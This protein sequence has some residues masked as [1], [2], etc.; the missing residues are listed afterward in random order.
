[1]ALITPK[2]HA[3]LVGLGLMYLWCT[4]LIV[5]VGW[6]QS[7]SLFAKVFGIV[8]AA[9]ASLSGTA[10]FFFIND[11]ECRVRDLNE[12]KEFFES[13]AKRWTDQAQLAISMLE[14]ERRRNAQS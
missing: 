5:C 11:L 2:R 9:V 8:G 14:K 6:W 12:K 7:G 1:M 4:T 13:E 10:T 3:M